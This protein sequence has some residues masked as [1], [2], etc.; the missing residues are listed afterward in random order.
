MKN[1]SLKILILGTMG[2]VPFA[3]MVWQI[4]HYVEGL[5]RLG[6]DVYYFE[7]TGAWPYDPREDTITDDFSFTVRHIETAMGSIGLKDKWAYRSP[8]DG[9]FFGLS[10][11]DAMQ[12]LRDADCLINVTGA[13]VLKEDLLAVPIRIYMETDPG[14]P[15]IEIDCGNQYTIDFLGSHTHHFTFGENEGS[16]DCLMPPTPFNYHHTRQP[17]VTDWWGFSPDTT[18]AHESNTSVRFTSIASWK[19]TEKDIDWQGKKYRWSKHKNFERYI[20][21][22]D[23]STEAFELALSGCDQES[24]QRLMSNQWRVIDAVSL[25]L[26]MNKYRE[27]IL[28]SKGEFTVAKEQYVDLNT[29]WF[30][31]RSASYLAAGRPVITQD[32][33][34]GKFLPTGEGLFAFNSIEDVLSALETITANY[35]KHRL[36]ARDVAEEYFKAETVMEKVISLVA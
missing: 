10:D 23:L 1:N 8:L 12:L 16:A 32:T 21:L 26:D 36:A 20:T 6:H 7:D 30:S 4:L 2:Q 14:L 19:Q 24:E 22:P 33:G 15:Q 31:D 27:Y 13:T 28:A 25:S 34:F 5:K 3:G 17:I 29:G 9:R 11:K 35:D 18:S